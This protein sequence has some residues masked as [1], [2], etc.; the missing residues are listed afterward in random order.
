MAE[1]SG[2]VQALRPIHGSA[3]MNVLG[4]QVTLQ[5]LA[6]SQ[7]QNEIRFS[8]KLVTALGK[9]TRCQTGA[10]SASNISKFEYRLYCFHVY[11]QL[12]LVLELGFPVTL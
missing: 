12:T 10:A 5:V 8:V 6:T 7:R 9:T 3:S 11:I 4:L 1:S 2:G